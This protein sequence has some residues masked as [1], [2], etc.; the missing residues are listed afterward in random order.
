MI[1]SAIFL[2][3]PSGLKHSLFFLVLSLFSSSFSMLRYFSARDS[4]SCSW[5]EVPPYEIS[6]PRPNKKR[7]SK[8]NKENVPHA[9][10]AIGIPGWQRPIRQWGSLE[11]A[12]PICSMAGKCPFVLID[13]FLPHRT[14]P[15]KTGLISSQG[16][17]STLLIARN[18]WDFIKY[19]F[20]PALA[21]FLLLISPGGSNFRNQVRN[22]RGGFLPQTPNNELPITEIIPM[23]R[24]DAFPV[25]TSRFEAL[26]VKRSRRY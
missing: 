15:H 14:F 6:P 7:L 26:P 2:S 16:V 19:I 17:F 4:I 12:Y 23:G 21:P 9:F 18:P 13:Y 25:G 1:I 3:V 8:T 20:N 22:P 11:Q 24:I 5:G 10:W